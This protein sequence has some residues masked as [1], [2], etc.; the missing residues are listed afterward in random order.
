MVDNYRISSPFLKTI[1]PTMDTPHSMWCRLV[2]RQTGGY[3]P[4]CTA[5]PQCLAGT[6]FPSC[7][8]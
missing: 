1:Q 5:L 2:R 8:V 4:S 7:L 3:L 6:H